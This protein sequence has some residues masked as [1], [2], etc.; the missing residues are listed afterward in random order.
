MLITFEGGEGAGKS[1]LIELLTQKFKECGQLVI[2][3]REPGGT[4][5]GEQVRQILLHQATTPICDVA[6]ILLFLT[7]RAQQIAEVIQPH[8]EKGYIVLCDR[9]NDSTVAYQGIA[10]GVGQ[11][12]TEE[13]CSLACKHLQPHLTFVLDLDPEI[14]LHRARGHDPQ[15]DRLE[16]LDIDFHNKVRKGYQK[17]AKENPD[18]VILLDATQSP[19]AIF[20]RCFEI[21]ESSQVNL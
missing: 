17:L 11:E 4:A 6:E 14:G 12:F 21:I 5:L 8:L 1:T 9:Y 18:R 15:W 13:L 3:T 20:Q 16:S 10:R 7:S 2:K 19:E